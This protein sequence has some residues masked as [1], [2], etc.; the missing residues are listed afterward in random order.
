MITPELP[1]DAA[2][3]SRLRAGFEARIEAVLDSLSGSFLDE[4]AT[5]A[6]DACRM[7]ELLVKTYE[8]MLALETRHQPDLVLESSTADDDAD[9]DLSGLDDA[10]LIERIRP[11]LFGASDA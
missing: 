2:R 4:T 9:E 8:R 7:L 6:K 10:E 11:Y 1:F 3:L 5:A